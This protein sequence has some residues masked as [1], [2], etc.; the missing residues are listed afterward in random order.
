VVPLAAYKVL[1]TLFRTHPFVM[2]RANE[3]DV[4][5]GE[6]YEELMARRASRIS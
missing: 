1:L 5:I 6:G 4:W 2:Q 3:L